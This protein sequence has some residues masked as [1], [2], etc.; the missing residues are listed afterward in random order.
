MG[1][2]RKKRSG[3]PMSDRELR[4]YGIFL[5]AP[6]L[7]LT[8]A[9]VLLAAGFIREKGRGPGLEPSGFLSQAESALTDQEVVIEPD[10]KE[11]S[12]DF[13]G[14]ILEKD[15]HH[16]INQLM[17]DYFRSVSECDMDTF[18]NLFT[19]QD[20]SQEEQF[21]ESF[22]IQ[23]EYIEG[24]ENISCY[25]AAGLTDGSYVVYVSYDVKFTGV[26]TPAPSLVRVY[27]EKCGDGQWRIFDGEETPE[28]AA[29]L[30][31][32]SGNEDVVL[33]GKQIDDAKAAAMEA[34]EELKNRILFMENGPDYMREGDGGGESV[35]DGE[36]AAGTVG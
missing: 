18:M 25:T 22:E 36:N 23:R 27:A 32:V 6:L 33:L 29:Y 20:T 5:L 21:R 17:E 4:K 28:L 11:Y 2:S 12:Y 15:A 31:A 9:A 7:V 24:Y 19:S 16:E 1:R 30:D 35:K 13:G 8:L 10:T 14:S 34:D 3:N 26:Q